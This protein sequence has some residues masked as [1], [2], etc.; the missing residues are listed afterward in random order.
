M[1]NRRIQQARGNSLTPERGVRPEPLDLQLPVGGGGHHQ[2]PHR[3]APAASH[4]HDI[5][6]EC[7]P[8]VRD[9]RPVPIRQRVRIGN[10]LP[11]LGL[12][13]QVVRRQQRAQPVL[14][15]EGPAWPADDGN[16]TL[17][18]HDVKYPENPG[19]ARPTPGSSRT[20]P[21]SNHLHRVPLPLVRH[22]LAEIYATQGRSEELRT[23]AGSENEGLALLLADTLAGQDDL[24]AK[25]AVMKVRLQVDE[26][27]ARDEVIELLR[28]QDRIDQAITFLQRYTHE[29]V[30]WNLL[31]RL[32]LLQGRVKDV[33]LMAYEESGPRRDARSMVAYHFAEQ[34]RI[35]ELRRLVTPG[36]STG[37]ALLLARA[38][39]A[40]GRVDE[41]VAVLQERVDAD[42]QHSRDWLIQLL[43]EQGR[44]DEAVR[45]LDRA[46][47]DTDARYPAAIERLTKAKAD[48]LAAYDR[49]DRNR[50]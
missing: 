3:G 43:V 30:E 20:R 33:Q 25:V 35:D 39:V 48:L 41:G 6:G 29:Y 2:T 31:V 21:I 42:E 22:G 17:I 13:P 10:G 11:L 5:V 28:A 18:S 47:E 7:G 38:L 40:R 50:N 36:S 9:L 15:G 4:Q 24:E 32:L 37:L 45:A 23:L 49:P 27:D 46:V 14:G 44:V 1:R 16:L 26:E 19:T 34:G 8:R 12:R